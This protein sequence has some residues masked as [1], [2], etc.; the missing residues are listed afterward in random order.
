MLRYLN[1]SEDFAYLHLQ[2]VLILTSQMIHQQKKLAF[3][4]SEENIGAV[5][6]VE[7]FTYGII[8]S[9]TSLSINCISSPLVLTT[10]GSP[11]SL[12]AFTIDSLYTMLLQTAGS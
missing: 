12:I 1:N 5:S 11:Y 2:Q 6:N 10:A 8:N 4:N 3:R 7:I 9:H